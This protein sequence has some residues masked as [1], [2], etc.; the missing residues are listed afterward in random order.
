[1]ASTFVRH[2]L[3]I[4]GQ[5][6]LEILVSLPELV[7]ARPGIFGPA[8]K[9]ILSWVVRHHTQKGN[10]HKHDTN[11]RKGGGSYKHRCKHPAS[12]LSWLDSSTDAQEP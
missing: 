12:V 11:I 4:S 1:M 3:D 8:V 2:G 6:F 7:L 5:A 10:H 9:L